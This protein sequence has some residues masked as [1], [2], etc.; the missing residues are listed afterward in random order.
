[1]HPFQAKA[2]HLDL[3]WHRIESGPPPCCP[4][5][6]MQWAHCLQGY[7]LHSHWPWPTIRPSW[8]GYCCK[9]QRVTKVVS[10]WG[11][12]HRSWL[13]DWNHLHQPYSLPGPQSRRDRPSRQHSKWV[14]SR[15]RLVLVHLRS[16][17]HVE[18]WRSQSHGDQSMGQSSWKSWAPDSPRGLFED[19]PSNDVE[20]SAGSDSC[21]N[22]FGTGGC[23]ICS[24]SIWRELARFFFDH[25]RPRRVPFRAPWLGPPDPWSG[26]GLRPPAPW[27]WSH[28]PEPNFEPCFL[29]GTSH[30]PPS[31]RNSECVHLH[32]ALRESRSWRRN[33]GRCRKEWMRL[34][35]V[36]IRCFP[37]S[38]GSKSN[39]TLLAE[40][41]RTKGPDN[42]ASQLRPIIITNSRWRGT[43]KA[44]KTKEM[45]EDR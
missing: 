26:W 34:P 16:H 44:G 2:S 19:L 35:S 14:T 41:T 13:V 24:G 9:C 31:S 10:P 38:V 22:L 1:M 36:V 12:G 32:A 33:S 4:C 45:V 21:E 39:H 15:P 25:L 3:C 6:W 43:E 17:S 37:G 5:Q 40:G 28:P 42:P 29:S 7:L 18:T 23:A 30:A 11:A 8:P 27:S 20:G